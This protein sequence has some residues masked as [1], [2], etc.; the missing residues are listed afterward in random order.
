MTLLAQLVSAPE[1]LYSAA[2]ETPMYVLVTILAANVLVGL[3]VVSAPIHDAHAPRGQPSFFC[4][5]SAHS[6]D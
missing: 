6:Q 5:S 2:K 3:S 4:P 1:Q